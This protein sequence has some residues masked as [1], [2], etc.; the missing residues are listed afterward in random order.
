MGGLLYKATTLPS[1]SAKN[2]D[3]PVEKCPLPW[4]LSE[5]A[6]KKFCEISK[7]IPQKHRFSWLLYDWVL[8]L[9]K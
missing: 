2:F 1:L 5:V 6:R 7:A 4:L 9:L 3:L 8:R